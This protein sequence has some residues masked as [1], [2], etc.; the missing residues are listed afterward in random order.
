MKCDLKNGKKRR[1]KKR[2][3]QIKEA[4]KG[5]SPRNSG[6]TPVVRGSSGA[7]APPLAARP[8]HYAPCHCGSHTTCFPGSSP[9]SSCLL[10]APM[11]LEIKRPLQTSSLPRF[12][13]PLGN[14]GANKSGCGVWGPGESSRFLV[15]I[16]LSIRRLVPKNPRSGA[17]GRRLD[18]ES[19][20]YSPPSLFKST[21]F[22]LWFSSSEGFGTL[23]YTFQTLKIF[24]TFEGMSFLE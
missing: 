16:F 12:S 6:P 10:F 7:K 22:V 4:G 15:Q 3:T 11:K 19:T 20:W 14:T 13:P 18:L 2:Q 17:S 8:T 21:L 5:Q 24:Q 9:C 1:G 23:Y